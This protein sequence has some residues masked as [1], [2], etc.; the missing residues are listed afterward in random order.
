MG[1]RILKTGL[2]I[3]LL[4]A[5]SYGQQVTISEQ[6]QLFKTYSFG[7]PNPIPVL[8]SNTKIYPYHKFDGYDTQAK[9]ASWKVVTLE[10]D[11][12]QV[13]VLPEVGGKVWGGIDK[14]TG[15]E[16]IYRNEV[17]KFRNISMRGPWT[18]GGIEFNFGIIGHHPSTATPVDYLIR[19]N[20]DGSVSC[21]V[22]NID[23]PSRTQW[24][25]NITLLPDKSYFETKALWY[26]PTPNTQSYYNWMTA[27]AFAT[28]DLEFFTPGN[29]YL[30][31]SGEAKSWPYD[32][33]RH[34]LAKY[35][36]NNFGGSKSYHVVG[37]YND[38][39]G[40]YF[41]NDKYGF[42]HWSTYEEMP[43][44]KL[45]IWALSRS[46]GIWED[47]LTDNDGQYIEF[48][49]GRLLDQYSPGNHKNPITQVPFGSYYT[50]SWRELW[51]PYNEIGGLSEVSPVAAMHVVRTNG[52]VTIGIN[53]LANV[54]GTLIAKTAD[55]EL[56]R[57]EITLTPSEVLLETISLPYSTEIE[58]M[59]KEMDLHYKSGATENNLKR[60]FEYPEFT[61][62]NASTELY[63]QG[64]EDLQ[65]REFRKARIAFEQCLELDPTHVEARAALA[66]IFFRNAEYDFALEQVNT[67]LQLDTY[68]PYSNY[69]A[70]NI[71]RA[72]GD[73]SNAMESFGWA[74]RSLDFRSAA[75]TQMSEL[76]FAKGRVLEAEDLA[77]KALSFNTANI[78]A[79]QLLTVLYRR[80]N[81]PDKAKNTLSRLMEIDPLNHLGHFELSKYHTDYHLEE[82]F[83]SELVEQTYLE[84]AI[85]YFNM[86]QYPEAKE[87]LSGT[88]HVV[89]WLWMAYLERDNQ[90]ESTR[91]LEQVKKSKVE[92][93]FPFRRET[94][95]VLEWAERT[96]NHWKFKYYLGL[97]YWGKD[98]LSEAARL[99]NMYR[100]NPDEVVFYLSRALLLN[101][102]D[103]TDQLQ[104][105]EKAMNLDSD[106]WRVWSNMVEYY[107]KQGNYEKELELADMAFKKWPENY[108]LGLSYARSL[109]HNKQY[110]KCISQ[111]KKFQI[112]PFEGAGGSRVIYER[113]YLGEAMRVMERGQYNKAITLLEDAKKWPENLGV[114]KPY[115]PEQRQ[116]DYL[117]GICYQQ[118]GQTS[119]QVVS[120]RALEEYTLKYYKNGHPANILGILSLSSNNKAKADAIISELEDSDNLSNQWVVAQ[121]KSDE[122]EIMR[123]SPEI[124]RNDPTGYELLK[125]MLQLK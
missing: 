91:W 17:M 84:L 45:W 7:D 49:A 77:N 89:A 37:E 50:D 111:L 61:Q 69:V 125:Q 34:N 9:D 10:N 79:L 74:A 4:F 3:C 31:H 118:L 35:S 56:L 13:F 88:D 90:D 101:E 112:L 121:Y 11:Y 114:G 93:V 20:E 72:Q 2:L 26:N 22:G 85:S 46:G 65:F 87:I 12:I 75:Y 68:R 86:G 36:E 103:G 113:A 19:E 58:V 32:N 30:M 28:E 48:Q 92:F 100:F 73:Y 5:T 6:S 108:D 15:Q 23:L 39:F 16:F 116:I 64:L 8:T 40:G 122:T 119:N 94:I 82:H 109:L 83:R 102:F 120:E 67:A 115:A 41:H 96:D 43:G 33:E 14:S 71:Y 107:S 57:K 21:I 117:Q 124:N 55:K 42:G 51:F 24:R 99:M 52:T 70:G 80:T 1:L 47:L 105:L 95:A 110:S 98:R 66:E 104:D 38:F 97:V 29:Q 62:V 76:A 54:S 44:Q 78:S 59:V 81:R 60:P 27:A 18:S 25:V 63:S 106:N 123:L 53:G